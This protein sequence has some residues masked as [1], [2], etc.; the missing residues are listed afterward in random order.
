V[1][2]LEPVP[3]I[4]EVVA[5]AGDHGLSHVGVAGADVLAETRVALHERKASGLHDGMA[6]TYKNPDRSTDPQRAVAGARSVIVAARPYLTDA[7]PERPDAS[8]PQARVGR[9]AWVDHYADLRDGLRAIAHRIR[10]SGHKAV[11]FADDNSMVDRAIAHRAGLGWFGKNSN[12]LL[13]GAGSF[14]VLGSIVTTAAYEAADRAAPDGCGSCDRCL[15]GC[16]TE[17]IV[18]PGVIDGARC[19]S[20]ILQK[21]G[22]IPDAFRVAVHD[23]IY[24]C[25]DCQ[26]VC[27]ISVRLGHRNTVPLDD[28]LADGAWVDALELLDSH[29]DELDA[30]HGH[31]YVANREF[32]WLRRN[33]LVV[34]GNVARSDDLRVHSTI[35]RYRADPDPILAEHADWA[36]ARLS[37]RRSAPS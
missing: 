27:P 33:A 13:P 34:L 21:P 12:L 29:D 17:A 22:A 15:D 35:E 8:A 23:R 32:R 36:A 7:E 9:F 19:L 4:D 1:C 6:F 14:F 24:G 26:D 2:D 30:R 25:D 11:A 18:A 28:R 16:P 3:T 31:W 10:R 20:W 5:L 37:E